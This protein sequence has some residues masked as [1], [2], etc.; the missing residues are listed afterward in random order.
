MASV[1]KCSLILHLSLHV[2][3]KFTGSPTLTPSLYLKSDPLFLPSPD[4]LSPFAFCFFC[5]NDKTSSLQRHYAMK[6]IQR[7][8]LTLLPPR[9][10]S[11][12]LLIRSHC[13]LYFVLSQSPGIN[14]KIIFLTLRTE[15]NRMKKLWKMRKRRMISPKKLNQLL[16][17]FLSLSLIEVNVFFP[18]LSLCLLLTVFFILDTVVRWSAAKGIG[19]ISHRLPKVDTFTVLRPSKYIY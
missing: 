18:S 16:T 5:R 9:R 19:R 6:L 7:V 4:F 14:G 8:G 15:S 13:Y 12:R 17:F 3:W 1:S 2:L 11:W 10:L